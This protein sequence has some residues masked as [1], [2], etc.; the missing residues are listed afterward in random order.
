MAD[1]VVLYLVGLVISGIA[2]ANLEQFGPV[3]GFLVIGIGVVVVGL[4]GMML[5]YLD[6][7]RG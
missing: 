3:H 1:Y 2:V 4:A 6:G 5:T 7:K